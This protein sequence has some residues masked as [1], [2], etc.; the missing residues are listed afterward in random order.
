[1]TSM[2]LPKVKIHFS[3]LMIC[4]VNLLT[5]NFLLFSLMLFCFFSHE[6]GHLF[7]IYMKKGKVNKIE[8]NAFGASIQTSLHDDLLVNFGRHPCKS[9]PLF[10]YLFSKK[11]LL[12]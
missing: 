9:N 8:I 2:S 10:R 7:F 5:D 1:M 4:I 3:F 11:F 12:F 6:L